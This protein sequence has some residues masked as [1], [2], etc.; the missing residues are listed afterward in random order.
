MV[1][2]T[3]SVSS[4]PSTPPDGET[5]TFKDGAT[6]L[7]TGTLSGGVATLSTSSLSQG[8]HEIHAIYPGDAK[9]RA[10]AS[11]LLKQVVD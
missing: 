1:T 9:L 10:S 2:F 11:P 8:K 3:A 6:V 4:S 5:V 7:G